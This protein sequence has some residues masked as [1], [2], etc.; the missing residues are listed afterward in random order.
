MSLR[1]VLLL[2]LLCLLSC[3]HS[4]PGAGE[5]MYV[6]AP[7]ANLRDRVATVYNRVG[8]LKNGERVDVLERQRRFVRVRT[9]QKVE[10]WVEL[11]ALVPSETYQQFQQ[12]SKDNRAT[13]A[14][15]RGVTRVELNM[16]VAPGRETDTLYQLS[17]SS[18]VEMLKRATTGRATPEEIAARRSAELARAAGEPTKQALKKHPAHPSG[19]TQP[20]TTEGS[21]SKPASAT[22]GPSVGPY[23]PA[24]A[25]GGPSP[26]SAP[27]AASPA[28]QAETPSTGQPAQAEG[29]K[30]KPMDDWW[31]VRDQ[32]G[33]TGWV[34][35]HMVDLDVPL[36]VAQYAEG[37]RI[38]AAFV[39]NTVQDEAK[40]AVPQYLVLLNDNRDGLAYDFNQV[41]VFTWNLKK[42][43]YETGYREHYI[44]GYFPASVST[45]DFG[46]EGAMPVFIIRK[47]DEDGSIRERKYRVI[48]NIV[49][50]V[51]APGEVLPHA[52]HSP[53][54]P[55]KRTA[56]EKKTH[57]AKSS[58]RHR[59]KR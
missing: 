36:D 39:L 9:A 57:P 40:G 34:L 37:Q 45:E 22:G 25:T 12:L 33:H 41:R 18:K 6:S 56:T 27:A 55:K 7:Q 19:K 53:D 14:Q 21:K 30:P 31:L 48:G 1:F 8:T 20:S 44:V 32:Q 38:Q 43:R 5:V 15:G 59:K 50:P 2:V 29:D 17:E 46:R 47:Q 58:A 16:H 11:R 52:A 4:G 3:K 42:H 10:G 13:P 49:R 35:A 28:N 26:G 54:Q 51:L 23:P 24:S